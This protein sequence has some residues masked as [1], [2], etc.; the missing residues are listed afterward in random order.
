MVEKL[1][2]QRKAS[3]FIYKSNFIHENLQNCTSIDKTLIFTHLYTYYSKQHI[4]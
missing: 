4:T 1:H 2:A 3:S